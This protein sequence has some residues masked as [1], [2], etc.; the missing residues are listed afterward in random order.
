VVQ[1]NTDPPRDLG[2][3]QG[4]GC[5]VDND[6]ARDRGHVLGTD[7]VDVLQQLRDFHQLPVSTQIHTLLAVT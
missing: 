4:Q 2:Q 1:L 6:P 5:D 3:G 7:V